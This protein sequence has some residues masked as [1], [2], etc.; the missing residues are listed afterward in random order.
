MLFKNLSD[1]DFLN[2][3]IFDFG[4]IYDDYANLRR[5]SSKYRLRTD[6][7]N[8]GWNPD[9][10]FAGSPR[11]TEHQIKRPSLRIPETT[12]LTTKPNIYLEQQ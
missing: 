6:T 9:I 8:K 11:I 2:S 4:P 5:T 7:L 12:P 10:L 1:T 3:Q